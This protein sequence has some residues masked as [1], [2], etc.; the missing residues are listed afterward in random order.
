MAVTVENLKTLFP[1]TIGETSINPHLA[2]ATWDYKAEEFEDET[3][4]LEVIGSKTL[5]YLAPLLWVDMQDRAEE[6]A[7][8]V[9]T[10]KD[11]KKFQEYWLDRAESA[12]TKVTEENKDEIG[13][14]AI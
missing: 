4:E 1:L 5:Y 10:F 2:R 14:L 13:W 8:S 6:Y 7:E 3:Q 11:V 9:E 12:L